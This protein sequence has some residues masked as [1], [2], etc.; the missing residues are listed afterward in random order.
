[1]QRIFTSTIEL[2]T[3]NKFVQ[4]PCAE[5]TKAECLVLLSQGSSWG[6]STIEFR[7]SPVDAGSVFVLIPGAPTLSPPVPDTGSA[8]ITA[9]FNIGSL[10]RLRAVVSA[11][12]PAGRFV[13]IQL[14]LSNP[15]VV[16]PL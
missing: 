2:D 9:E 12:G 3:T 14:C 8:R 4:V 1:M 5:M 11:A 13:E 6:T 10:R 15:L 16:A 7:G